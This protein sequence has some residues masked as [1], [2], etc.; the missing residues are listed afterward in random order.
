[1]P[2]ENLERIT[3]LLQA[4]DKDFARAMD[5]NNK[6]IARMTRDASK[7]TTGMA[8]TVD[9]NLTKIS[10]S[11]TAMGKTFIAGIAAGAI[12][13]S[14]DMVLSNI[15]RTVN[16]IAQIG[17]EAKRSGLG[18][19]EFQEWS[20]V[21]DQ[22]RISVDSLVDGFKELN[23]RVDEFT[24]TGVGP[25]AEA[26]QRLGYTSDEL[27]EKIKKP[28]DLMLEMLGRME[29]LDKA[30]QIRI[31]DELFGGTAGER[32]VELLGQGQVALT[33][34]IERAHEVGAV[35]DDVMIKK[36]DQI[37]RQWAA[38]SVK[39]QGYAK[40][41]AMG[42][43]E[44]LSDMGTTTL[45][46]IFPNDALAKSMLGSDVFAKFSEIGDLRAEQADEL[47]KLADQIGAV[48]AESEK[49]S[50][51][52]YADAE[53]SGMSG[54]GDIGADLGQAAQN[55]AALNAQLENGMIDVDEYNASLGDTLDS[56]M[57]AAG[58]LENVAG[59]D[60]SAISEQISYIVGV[61]S[62][63]TAQSD[64]LNASLANRPVA[65]S[66]EAAALS[67][68]AALGRQAA[69]ASDYVA[70]QERIQSLTKDQLSLEREIASVRSEA[71]KKGLTLSDSQVSS[72]AQGNIAAN[73][74]RS[75][76]GRGGGSSSSVSDDMREAARWIDKTRTALELYEADIAELEELNAKG[77]FAAHPEAYSRAI[78][79]VEEALSDANGEASIFLISALIS[80]RPYWMWR[81]GRQM[82]LIGCGRLS[83][84]PLWNMRFLAVAASLVSVLVFRLFWGLLLV[85]PVAELLDHFW[86][87]RGLVVG[88]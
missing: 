30:A 15:G 33:D 63:A 34:T 51:S 84:V 44:V 10:K 85:A 28:S 66:P 37:D 58:S 48:L 6:L 9:G 23:L 12:T 43:A 29:G 56:A 54:F 76:A 8:R 88:L 2:D 45:D 25:A 71:Q 82:L 5:R 49:L 67:E 79:M 42:W 38:L 53:L 80:V 24:V 81:A 16:G 18:V 55:I 72:I 40:K 19:E 14:L 3:I 7:N 32:F 20:Y 59:V 70:E 11:A 17:N 46:D 1:M 4:K 77:F 64:S 27:K 83:S 39:M 31:S 13:A 47:R 35:L 69:A 68:I 78:E 36:A 86:V 74:S 41:A 61:L 75:G 62:A 87:V 22:N 60:M 50:G 57:D 26:L 73:S 52:L 65:T 21:A